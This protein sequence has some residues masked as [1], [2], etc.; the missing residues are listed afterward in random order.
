MH[1]GHHTVSLPFDAVA[2]ALAAA[3]YAE[4][5]RSARQGDQAPLCDYCFHFVQ[6]GGRR[7]PLHMAVEF[8]LSGGCGAPT[9]NK[10]QLIR[11]IG[12][13]DHENPILL[14]TQ[15]GDLHARVQALRRLETVFGA[16]AFDA[17]MISLVRWLF[18]GATRIFSEPE[19]G[20]TVRRVISEW[21]G[22]H[23]W[24]ALPCPCRRCRGGGTH[25]V[26]YSSVLVAGGADE[27]RAEFENII[28]KTPIVPGVT[29]FCLLCGQVSAISF[30]YDDALKALL[31]VKAHSFK[32]SGGYYA[33]L[34]IKHRAHMAL[35]FKGAALG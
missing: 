32:T 17:G 20:R 29:I 5:I 24:N 1:I 9:P 25:F 21:N 27:L 19:L 30:E 35:F 4:I 28:E 34:A 3:P 6:S 15:G 7:H 18:E 13:M 33:H 2:V 11:W 26:G 31:D 14:R 12:G 8:V 23:F 22:P 10:T 16:P